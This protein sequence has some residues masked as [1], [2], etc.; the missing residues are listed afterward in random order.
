[1]DERN[2]ILPGKIHAAGSA[3]I[4]VRRETEL[5][6]TL[7]GYF[8][9]GPKTYRIEAITVRPSYRRIHGEKTSLPILCTLLFMEPK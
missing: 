2:S 8:S 9:A 3:F 6:F 7:M 1:M 5:V 4:F